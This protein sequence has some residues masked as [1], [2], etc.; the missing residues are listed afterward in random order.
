MSPRRATS[1]LVALSALFASACDDLPNVDFER[2]IV[3][4]RYR[5]WRAAPYFADGRV[6]RTPPE[7]TLPKGAMDEDPPIDPA[8]TRLSIALDKGVLTAGRSRFET[9]C[10]PC[11]GLLGDGQTVV[12]NN[13]DLRRPPALAGPAS[14]GLPEGRIHEIIRDGY[15]LMRSYRGELPTAEE[16]LSVIAYLRA[17][18]LSRRAELARLPAHV[19]R[20][21]E[22]AIR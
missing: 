2:M 14:R 20:E 4:H 17:L 19:R 7:G 22:E 6:M 13:M 16:R 12:A 5:V 3:Q 9:F 8:V 21:A 1:A 15:G 10:A 18:D 11:H